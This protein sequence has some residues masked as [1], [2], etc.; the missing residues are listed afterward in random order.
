M[1]IPTPKKYVR[2]FEKLGFGMFIHF[3]LYSQR[4]RGEWAKYIEG[5]PDEEYNKLFDTFTAEDFD[6]KDIARTAKAAGAK[7]IV[8]TTRHHEGFSLYDTQGLSDFDAPHSPAGRDLIREYVDACN[9]EGIIPF[10]YHTTLDWYV[11]SFN[12]DFDEYLEYLRKSVEVLCSRYGK[13]GGLWFDGNWSKK[14]ADWKEDELYA[15]I[16]HYQPD[17]IIV[18]NTGLS[19]R[20]AFGNPEIDSVTF[21]Q[22]RPEPL[23]REGMPKYVACEMCE[24]INDHWGYGAGDFNCK[25]SARLIETLCHCRKVGANYLLNI[26]PREQGALDPLQKETLKAIGG[27]LKVF[28]E[29]IYDTVPCG[30]EGDYKNFGLKNEKGEVYLF[31]HDLSRRGDSNVTTEGGGCGEKAFRGI[32]GD[33]KS[34]Q[35]LDDGEELSFRKEGDALIV[36]CT[37]YPYGTSYVVRVA[38]VTF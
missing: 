1:A 19:A 26:G 3:G 16:R 12:E 18:N 35:W 11:K 14:D 6:A 15:T 27:W 29:A 24:T 38:K 8:L 31:V 25:S 2:D 17:A 37:G 22:G 13:I 28:G 30:I 32:K 21:E 23:N 33:I 9:E 4:G 5:I 7:Y 36:N 20:G 34:I 10:F